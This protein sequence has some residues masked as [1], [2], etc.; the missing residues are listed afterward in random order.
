MRELLS[1][2][3][4]QE[5]EIDEDIW[6]NLKTGNIDGLEYDGGLMRCHPRGAPEGFKVEWELSEFSV[7]NMNC[8]SPVLDLRGQRF[9]ATIKKQRFSTSNI[10]KSSTVNFSQ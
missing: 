5:C 10:S 6:N 3:P 1:M 7:E 8:G 2:Y 4:Y 9:S